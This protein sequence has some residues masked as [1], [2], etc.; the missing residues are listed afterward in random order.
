MRNRNL[1]SH[2][3]FAIIIKASTVKTL[4]GKIQIIKSFVIPKILHRAAALPCENDF[5]KEL[6]QLLF[7]FLWR[8]KDKIKRTAMINKIEYGGLKMP[9][10]IL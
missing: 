8:G 7:E 1:F 6:N 2:S 3:N 9:D 5:I 4:L 10:V